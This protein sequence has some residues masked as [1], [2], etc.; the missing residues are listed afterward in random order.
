MQND[1]VTCKASVTG[2]GS[3]KLNGNIRKEKDYERQQF[4]IHGKQFYTTWTKC[5]PSGARYVRHHPHYARE[6]WKRSFISTVTPTLH[7]NPS[8]KRSLSKARALQTGRIWKRLLCSLVWTENIFKTEIFQ[9]DDAT[10]T[11]WFQSEFSWNT[12]RKLQM[13]FFRRN[14]SGKRLMRFRLIP[15][16]WNFSGVIWMGLY[17]NSF[18]KKWQQHWMLSTF[19]C[20]SYIN[21]LNH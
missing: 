11:L 4:I 16:F 8:R 3:E 10:I 1:N 17:L 13:I 6:N 2:R 14:V 21:F 18:H 12:N 7:T 9:K 20:Q 15:P 5:L 19:S